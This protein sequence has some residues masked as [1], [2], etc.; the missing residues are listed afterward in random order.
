M[1]V[2][3]L[4]TY[5]LLSKGCYFRFTL[6]L[7]TSNCPWCYCVP[8]TGS[9]FTEA[10]NW[11]WP[12]VNFD[13]LPSFL[14]SKIDCRWRFARSVSRLSRNHETQGY[15]L[16]YF[17]SSFRSL[18]VGLPTDSNMFLFNGDIV[19]RGPHGPQV[20]CFDISDDL[21]SQLLL[22]VYCLKLCFPKSVFINRFVW[23]LSRL[24][25]SH[26]HVAA[27]ITNS[28]E[29]ITGISLKIVTLLISDPILIVKRF[30]KC[31]IRRWWDWS[32]AVTNGSPWHHS[33]KIKY[34]WPWNTNTIN[35]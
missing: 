25:L 6:R 16:L 12:N 26:V 8:K 32:E 14:I 13:S 11:R 17:S 28:R 30:L 9:V 7:R 23:A 4:G 22:S 20:P 2:W 18:N 35:F 24:L 10:Y 15:H 3:L 19:D 21:I 1:K 34:P 33:F 31:T 29:W 27:E 5:F